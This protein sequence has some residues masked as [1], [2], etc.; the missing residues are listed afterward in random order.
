MYDAVLVPTDGSPG[1]E[2]AIDRA[3]DLAKTYEAAFHTLYVVETA[4]VSFGAEQGAVLEYMEEAGRRAIDEVVSR[5]EQADVD[6]VEGSI[7]DGAPHRAILQYVTDREID[8]VVMGTH[9]RTGLDRYMLGSV[10]G[11]V[12]RLA[13]VPVLTVPLAEAADPD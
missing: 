2:A 9:G 8:V 5:A 10:T 11:K 4:S 7:M 3:I 1:S 12:V 6:S 13:D